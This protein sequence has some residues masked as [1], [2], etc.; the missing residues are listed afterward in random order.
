MAANSPAPIKAVVGLGNPGEQYD[1][2]RHNAGF[3]LVDELIRRFGGSLSSDK[4]FHGLAGNISIGSAQIRLLEPSTFMNESGRA[5]G[6]LAKYYNLEPEQILIVHDE[7]D[8]PAGTVRLKRGG[9]HGG[10][11]GL[12]DSIR[13]IGPDFARARVGIGHPGHK[14]QVL[15]YVL[16]RASLADQKL[17]DDSIDRLSSAIES[18]AAHGWDYA[19]KALHTKS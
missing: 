11:N 3:W 5:V 13:H 7:L 16:K 19:V 14:S 12:R 9:G 18:M 6:A 10:H 4:K 15:G 1:R 17:I 8:L 2:T